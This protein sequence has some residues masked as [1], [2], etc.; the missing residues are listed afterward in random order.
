M[1]VGDAPVAVTRA[2]GDAPEISPQAIFDYLYFH[3]VPARAPSWSVRIACC[4]AS[5]CATPM[6]ACRSTVTGSR[7]SSKSRHGSFA[8]LKA[9]FR[10]LLRTSVGDL[11][12]EQLGRRVPERRHRQFHRGRHDGGEWRGRAGCFSIGFDAEGYGRSRTQSWPRSFRR[13]PSISA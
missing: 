10:D 13:Q 6:A 9:E 4:P 8:D 1:A 7:V 5:T 3:M 2:A 11:V 12:R